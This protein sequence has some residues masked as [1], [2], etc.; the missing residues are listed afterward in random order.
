MIA[1][2]VKAERGNDERDGGKLYFEYKL[3]CSYS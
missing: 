2:Q 3:R 1:T